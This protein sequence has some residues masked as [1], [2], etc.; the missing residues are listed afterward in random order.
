MYKQPTN[1]LL[2]YDVFLIIYNM[3]SN[4]FRP[5]IQSSSR[6]QYKNTILVINVLQSIHNIFV[7]TLFE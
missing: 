5:V 2:F 1:A 7:I 3:F 6:W 4:M